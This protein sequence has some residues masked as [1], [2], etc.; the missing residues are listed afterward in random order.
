MVP[1]QSLTYILNLWLE[2]QL[3]KRDIIPT[4]TS[5]HSG[6]AESTPTPS[7]ARLAEV[8]SLGRSR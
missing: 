2:L 6:L 8:N 3:G 7:G 1:I 5:D 4:V